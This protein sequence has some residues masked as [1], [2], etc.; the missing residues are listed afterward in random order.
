MKLQQQKHFSESAQGSQL[1]GLW[2]GESANHVGTSQSN[3]ESP[4]TVLL[5]VDVNFMYRVLPT[6]VKIELD[7]ETTEVVKL[8][9]IFFYL[10]QVN[11]PDFDCDIVF[12]TVMEPGER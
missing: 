9:V 6:F 10:I 2:V 1:L 11:L 12:P 7:S 3:T 5:Q 4:N 8:I